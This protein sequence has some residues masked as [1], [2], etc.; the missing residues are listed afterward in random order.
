LAWSPTADQIDQHPLT[1]R[2]TDA[3]GNVREQTAR[4]FAVDAAFPWQ[5][6]V[7]S[8]DIDGNG[9]LVPLD[10]L[11]LINRLNS[12]APR[13]LP[14]PSGSEAPPPFY[15]PT[16][17]NHCTPQDVLWVV[18]FLNE[19]AS[20]GEG[21]A[22]AS[23]NTPT[24]TVFAPSISLNRA[25]VS[26][27]PAGSG[28]SNAAVAASWPNARQPPAVPIS[29]PQ[30]LVRRASARPSESATD[31][32]SLDALLDLLATDQARTLR[33]ADAA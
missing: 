27:S 31:A 24:A 20:E 9:S 6:P 13:T 15:D 2:A 28:G 17:D 8:L 26:A 19:R 14:T 22:E 16:K 3:A 7:E 25:P 11:L 12:P 5:N 4:L 33:L 18:N 10:A 21:E 30:T 1:L 29:P 32:N 23:F